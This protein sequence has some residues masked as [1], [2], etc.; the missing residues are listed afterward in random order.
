MNT[1]QHTPAYEQSFKKFL[2]NNRHNRFILYLAASAIVI[3]FGIFKYLY[4]YASYIHGDS[5]SYLNAADQN[6]TINTYIIGYSKFLRLFSV[7]AKPDYMLVAF[8][9]LLIQCSV[10][11][12]LF[13]IFYFYRPGKVTQIALLCFMVFN[14]LFL[15]L[16]NMVSSDGLFLALSCIWFA[17]LLWVIHRP[18]NSIIT[19][20]A[21]VLFIAFTVRYN[22]M[23]YPFIAG[24]AFWLS[25]LSLRKKLVGICLGLFFCGLF[26]AFTSYQYKKLTGYWQ[27]APFSGWQFANNAMYA[28]RD[29]DTVDY[30]SV[31][32]KFYVLDSMI[33]K[34][35]YSTRNVTL[36]PS[37]KAQA[38]TFYMWSSGMPLMDYRDSLFKKRDT[39]AIELKKWASMG[40]L[41]KAY[42]LFIIRQYPWQF[43]KSFMGPNARK[44]YA[45]PVEFL[46]EYNTGRKNVTD[47]AKTWFGYKSTKVKTRLLDN[48]VRVLDFY[49]ILSGIINVLMLFGLLYYTLLKGWQYNTIFNK[50]IIMAGTVWLINAGFTIFASSA[51]L[52]FQSFPIILTTTFALLLVDWMAQ[53]LKKMKSEVRERKLEIS[54]S[55][56]T[57]QILA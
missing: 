40:P 16:G 14:P 39:G 31:P 17:M 43:V 49:P 32:N 10:L 6:L 35:Y 3:Q 45:P 38:S 34:F 21:V 19:W 1:I 48:N 56:T 46:E 4:P 42:G 27:Y 25:E 54:S 18:S 50:T 9:Y 11:F 24:V 22:A 57:E 33:R 2:F 23:I 20:H 30:K 53:L 44:Y 52:R 5:F 47:Q 55:L 36:Y 28:Y 13:T 15:H 7:F 29:V 51:A 8:Q 12:L 37:E 41:Y 26:V